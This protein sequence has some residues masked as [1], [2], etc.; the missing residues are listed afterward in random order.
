MSALYFFLGL[1]VFKVKG[2]IG[3]LNLLEVYSSKRV[4]DFYIFDS[5][6]SCT[7]HIIM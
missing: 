3:F 1:S 2:R 5:N 6:S 4:S 7:A